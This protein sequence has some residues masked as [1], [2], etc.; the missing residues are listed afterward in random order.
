MIEGLDFGQAAGQPV[1]RAPVALTLTP[2]A[3]PGERP[4][5]RV[6]LAGDVL[7][8]A[9]ALACSDARGTDR[10]AG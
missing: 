7:Q 8:P 2:W 4:L 6:E 10:E 5:G 1:D 9:A 3:L